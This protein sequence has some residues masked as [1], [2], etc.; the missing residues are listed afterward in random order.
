MPTSGQDYF[1]CA[2][3]LSK[4]MKESKSSLIVPRY[5]PAEFHLLASESH[6]NWRGTYT[7]WGQKSNPEEKY[8]CSEIAF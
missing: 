1:S 5:R 3:S 8:N 4:Y 2:Q 7:K 6:R